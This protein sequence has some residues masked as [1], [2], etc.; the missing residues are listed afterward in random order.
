MGD[1]AV[2]EQTRGTSAVVSRAY[3]A[4]PNSCARA[5]ELLLR[6]L[7]QEAAHPGGPDDA[8][9]NRHVRATSRRP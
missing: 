6:N 1:G 4:D 3:R 2:S 7:G 8:E 5:L 9:K